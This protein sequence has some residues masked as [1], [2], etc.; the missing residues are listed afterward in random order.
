MS[1]VLEITN[2]RY[3][4]QVIAATTES[5]GTEY[6][7]TGGIKLPARSIIASHTCRVS[8]AIQKAAK[9]CIRNRRILRPATYRNSQ[10]EEK[11]E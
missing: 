1:K 8:I 10:K 7:T 4:V 6:K 2:A 11:R 9:T 3:I 5:G